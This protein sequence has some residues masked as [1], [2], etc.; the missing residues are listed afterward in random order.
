MGSTGGDR[1]GC[2]PDGSGAIVGV[3]AVADAEA[4]A[5]IARPDVLDR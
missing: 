3:D 5:G 1:R 4:V 2:P